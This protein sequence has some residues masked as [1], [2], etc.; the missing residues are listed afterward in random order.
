MRMYDA[1]IIGAGPGGLAA[2]MLLAHAGLK[3][4]LLERKNRPGGRCAAITEQGYRFDIGPTFFLYPRVLEDIYHDVGRDLFAEVPMTRLDP[5]YRLEFGA[6]GAINAT[7]DV[8]RMER[9][10]AA[11]SP[12]DAG[13]FERF[14]TDNRRK[15]AAFRPILESPWSRWT[16]FLS[17]SLL[18]AAFLLRPH[19]S[20]DA[21]LG[22]HFD[23]PRIRLAFSFQSKY[24]GMS[25]FRC[26]SL[27]SILS[28]LEYEYG[29][30]HPTGGCSA[31]SEHMAEVARDLGVDIGY[32][33]EVERLVF[34]GRRVV[35]VRTA[36]DEYRCRNLIINADFSRAMTRLVPDELRRRWTN[37]KL[38][39][40]RYSC[41]TFMMYLGIE[42]RYDNVA[43][44]TIRIAA[45]YAG[46][47]ADIETRH[48]L[49]N[50]PSIYVQNAG[51]TDAS[52]APTGH[53]TLYVLVPVTHQ[54]PNVDWS[55][56]RERYREVALDKLE[57]MGM[58]GIRERI[59]Y[60]RIC[61]PDDWDTSYEVHKGA[62]FNLAHNLGQMLHLRPQ[63]RFED[64]EGVY[65][66]G[67]GTH[68][69]SG[70]PVI[71]ESARITSKLLLAD[72][73]KRCSIGRSDAKPA[74]LA[75][76]H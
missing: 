50:D 40:K 27:F 21:D 76:R 63:N 57:A 9:E 65:L 49:S 58:T 53:S 35:G 6:G 70:L 66:V 29:V 14:M 41:S 24:L 54:H 64:L 10:I 48:M 60:E 34:S 13:R 45:D 7:P 46:N 38:A 52:L 36:S 72:W 17:P 19:K 69:G 16:D 56:E 18:K 15:L 42:G 61:T 4:K 20:L 74:E 3:V 67:G 71:Y 2:A 25:P 75:A 39:K 73:R 37:G 12:K 44:H 8:G 62:T 31:I 47:L 30:W 11:I 51:V 28:F 5:Q 55:V 59:R 23:D 68:P 26:P 32:E 1:L 43:H 22:S 33:E